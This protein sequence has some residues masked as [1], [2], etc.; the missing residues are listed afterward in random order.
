MAKI[1]V[2]GSTG[3]IGRR[4]IYH[5]LELGHE[6]YALCRI[7]GLL[8]KTISHSRLHILYGDLKDPPNM[9]PIPKDIEAAYYLVH[10]MGNLVQNLLEEEE[11]VAQNFLSILEKTECE[12]IIYLGGIVEDEAHLSPHLRSR[13]AVEKLLANSK[14][15]ATILRASIIIGSGS[16]SFEIIRD[17]VEKLPI[18]IAPKWVK[19]YCQPI[20]IRDVLFYLNGVLLNQACFDHTYE[21]GGP[22]VLSFKEV[23]LRYASYRKLKRFIFNVPCLTP[24]LS[25]YWL[26][27]IT[28]VRLSICMYLVES[29]KQNTRKLNKDIDKVLPHQCISF[30]EALK[31]AFQKIQQNEVISTWMDSWDLK[32]INPDIQQFIEVP[33][34]GC[35]QDIQV[36]QI[37]IPRDVVRQRI[38]SIGGNQGWYSMN[39]AW[40]LRGLIDQF[41]GGIGLNR[42]RKHPSKIEIGDSIDFWRVLLADEK[43]GHLI[44][45]SEMKLPGEAWLEFEINEKENTLKQTA[46]FRPKGFIGRIYW[47]ALWLIHCYIFKKMATAL[48]QKP[49]SKS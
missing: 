48:A 41:M 26:V 21:I 46:T 31:L 43:N 17:L 4:I 40:K 32:T 14:I 30:E 33:K 20:A 9:D 11:M 44:L 15:S 6:V 36:I 1:L 47:Y 10:S 45:F 25:S 39:W 34:E 42:G 38:W 24:K 22:E 12:Q 13:L 7:K 16:A 8:L 49:I 3:F 5:L 18:M 23:L 37:T 28:S 27:F 19:S 2:T 35:V 29:M